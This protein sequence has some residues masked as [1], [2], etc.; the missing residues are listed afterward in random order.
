MASLTAEQARF[1]IPGLTGTDSDTRLNT[2]V[3]R[4]DAA[5]AK[6]LGYPSTSA[7]ASPTFEDA[8]YT[9]YTGV[10]AARLLCLDAQTLQLPAWPLVS[11]TSI[12]DDPDRDYGASTL[13]D[14]GDYDTFDDEGL[15]V[16]RPDAT[17]AAWSTSRAAIKATVVVGFETPDDVLMQGC[18]MTIKHWW[19][20]RKK[21]GRTNASKRGGS[22]GNTPETLP[23][24]VRELLAGYQLPRAIL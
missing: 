17:H 6:W 12:Y 24:A 2:L 22:A 8:T 7:G 1:Y 15:I 18:G 16:L 10:G 11:V 9:W 5:I 21:Q 14:S 19:D 4:A 3:T 20:L 23:D 13:V